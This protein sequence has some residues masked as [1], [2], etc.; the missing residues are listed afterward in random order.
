MNITGPAL[1]VLTSKMKGKSRLDLSTTK[2]NETA[3]DNY[4]EDTK[5]GEKKKKRVIKKKK[6]EVKKRDKEATKKKPEKKDGAKKRKK[7]EG[8]KNSEKKKTSSK[9][10]WMKRIPIRRRAVGAPQVDRMTARPKVHG[11]IQV[12]RKKR[13]LIRQTDRQ[14]DR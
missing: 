6:K 11:Q 4:K 14:T 12:K 2:E 1:D 7:E 5:N 13:L 10:K 3:V 9:E 8:K